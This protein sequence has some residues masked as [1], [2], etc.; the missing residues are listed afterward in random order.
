M[1]TV[2]GPSALHLFPT[3]LAD[4]GPYLSLPPEALSALATLSTFIVE[5]ARTTRRLLSDLDIGLTISSCEFIEVPLE[6]KLADAERIFSSVAGREVGFLSEAGAPCIADP[7]AL[8]VALAHRQSVPVIPHGGPSAILTAVMSSGIPAQ[9]FTFHGYLSKDRDKRIQEIR[10]IETLS[11]RLRNAHAFMEA[12]YRSD[13][14]FQDILRTCHQ[15]TILA[16]ARSLE[17]KAQR[18]SA[19]SISKWKS[20]HTEL[21]KEPTI[22][23]LGLF[24]TNG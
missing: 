24:A 20:S 17:T 11:K 15:D 14:L 10:E 6:A 19:Q 23:V 2:S 5:N 3:P 21:G 12:P 4:N 16:V 13:A 1:S 9:S 18:I 8:F 22:F 7:G